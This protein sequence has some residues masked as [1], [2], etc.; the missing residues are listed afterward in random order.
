MKHGMRWLGALAAFAGAV[1]AGAGCRHAPANPEG[2]AIPQGIVERVFAADPP[3]P[4]V[5]VPALPPT[6]DPTAMLSRCVK[7]YGAQE[8]LYYQSE[9]DV[10]VVLN[11]T[12]QQVH[13]SILIKLD[14]P[15]GQGMLAIKDPIK[16][17]QLSTADARYVVDYEGAT[18]R[19]IRRARQ[20][21]FRELL[22]HLDR[23]YPQLLSPITF[24][25][26]GSLAF[27]PGSARAE[28]ESEVR[29]KPAFV[30]RVN[31]SASYL[32]E[33][34]TR[35]FQKPLEPASREVTLWLDPATGLLL[36]SSLNLSWTGRVQNQAG[37]TVLFNPSVSGTETTAR[38]VPNPRFGAEEFRFLPPEKAREVPV[39]S[40]R[41]ALPR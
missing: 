19:Y 10:T 17:T 16:G 11:K 9:A 20:G 18:N 35:A 8:T 34:A 26:V 22:D 32:R 15:G 29:G 6:S 3:P 2:P 5:A 36:K 28:P 13:Q 12:P 30:V 1:S 23:L 24:L 21:S 41:Q 4:G 40:R 37:T 7:A 27:E 31:L 39:E 38:F 33:F 14:R 25:R